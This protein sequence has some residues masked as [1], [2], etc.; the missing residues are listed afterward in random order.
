MPA[1]VLHS[2]VEPVAAFFR[3]S[4][5]IFRPAT[6]ARS[7]ASFFCS[8]LTRFTPAPLGLRSC[9]ALI[10]L[11]IDCAGMPSGAAFFLSASST[12]AERFHLA[13]GPVVWR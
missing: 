1:W 11:E 2:P 8:A 4:R 9:R 5:A 13:A 6:S 12:K 10:Q 3:I 7:L